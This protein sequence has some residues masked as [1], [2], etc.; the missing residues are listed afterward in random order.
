MY[1]IL[2]SLREGARVLDLGCYEGSFSAEAC[3]G[4][5]IVRL[6]RASHPAASG[7]VQGDATRLPFRSGSFDAVIANHCLEHIDDVDRV[8]R[9]IGRVTRRGG[10]LYVSVPDGSSWTDR[11]YRW[12]FH[13]GEHVNQFTSA[14]E[15]ASRISASTG[16]RLA[17]VRV[18]HS[19]LWFLNRARFGSRAPRKLLLFGNGSP[20]VIAWM[21]YGA[22]SM[23]RVLGTRLSVYGWALY[24][25]HVTTAIHTEP[26]TNVCVGCGTAQ[27]AAALESNSRVR[28]RLFRS[29]TCPACG[30]WNLFTPDPVPATSAAVLARENGIR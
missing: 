22:R 26:W 12:M 10:S 30:A 18:L 7:F 1:E 9:E 23:D 28:G 11:I 4:V 19:S 3:P 17:A 15:L 14:D 27:S 8:I 24:F 6:D 20:R 5:L 16:F 2:G 29:Y 13:G 21:S 25:G